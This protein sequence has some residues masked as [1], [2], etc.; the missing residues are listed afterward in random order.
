ML[1]E[2]VANVGA[3][4]G[5]NLQ[6]PLDAALFILMVDGVIYHADPERLLL[7]GKRVSGCGSK[8]RTGNTSSTFAGSDRSRWK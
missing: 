4:N 6:T 1:S 7:N 2:K 5:I 3:A 8:R